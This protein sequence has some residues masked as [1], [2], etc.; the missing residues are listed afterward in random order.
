M[1]VRVGSYDLDSTH[2]IPGDWMAG[3]E[4]GTRMSLPLVDDEQAIRVITSYSI[5]YTKLYEF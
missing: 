4:G 1:D 3:L 5:H 2:Q